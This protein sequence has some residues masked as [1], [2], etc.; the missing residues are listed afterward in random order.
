MAVS[1]IQV[2]CQSWGTCNSA[3]IHDYEAEHGVL[4]VQPKGIVVIGNSSEFKSR[5]QKQA[6]ELFRRNLHN[7]EIITYDELLARAKFIT[8][9]QSSTQS[10]PS[11]KYDPDIDDLPF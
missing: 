1:Q 10:Q 6:F 3:E 7:P 9:D 4:R 5:K 8:Q 11:E 2:Y